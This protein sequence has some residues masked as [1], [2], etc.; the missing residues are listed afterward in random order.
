LTADNIV[1]G[2][3]TNGR[4]LR[5]LPPLDHV[6]STRSPGQQACALGSQFSS[7][8]VFGEGGGKERKRRKGE[9]R[10]CGKS[11]TFSLLCYINPCCLWLCKAA[12]ML[13]AQPTDSI[14]NSEEMVLLGIWYI[15]FQ[16]IYI[17]YSEC[18]WWKCNILKK[19]SVRHSHSYLPLDSVVICT[20]HC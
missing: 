18:L 9:G 20:T 5:A 14:S 6:R 17:I 10:D 2:M 19:N 1:M 11:N 4:K 7:H 13:F 3:Q 16:Y 8:W 12:E 15:V